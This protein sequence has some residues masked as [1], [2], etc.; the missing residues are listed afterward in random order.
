MRTKM[1]QHEEKQDQH[2]HHRWLLRM[3]NPF[4]TPQKMYLVHM[5]EL[6]VQNNGL[7]QW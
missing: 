4:T 1:Q 2:Q 3:V 6:F 7:L 5:S